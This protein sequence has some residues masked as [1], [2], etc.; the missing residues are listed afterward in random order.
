[1]C[2]LLE[3]TL[4]MLLSSK[5]SQQ[6]QP[7]RSLHPDVLDRD[8][9]CE[10]ISFLSGLSCAPRVAAVIHTFFYLTF[11]PHRSSSHENLVNI[12]SRVI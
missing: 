4:G 8:Q 3:G 1:M 11:Y 6:L 9:N 7:L 5:I 2:I 10:K 12:H